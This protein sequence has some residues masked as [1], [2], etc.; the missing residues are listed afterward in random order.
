MLSQ[1]EQPGSPSSDSSFVHSRLFDVDQPY[2]AERVSCFETSRV[3]P[4]TDVA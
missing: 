2:S 4:P 1:R 3:V